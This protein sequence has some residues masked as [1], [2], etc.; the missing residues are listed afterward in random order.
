MTR[1]AQEEMDLLAKITAFIGYCGETG[2]PGADLRREFSPADRAYMVLVLNILREE[3]AEVFS[4][5]MAMVLGWTVRMFRMEAF[6]PY[7]PFL[8]GGD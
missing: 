3:Q 7:V 6:V 2:I 1:N 8:L 4:F 5:N